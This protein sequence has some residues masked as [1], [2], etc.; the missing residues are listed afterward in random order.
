MGRSTVERVSRR[1]SFAKT[2]RVLFVK[3]IFGAASLGPISLWPASLVCVSRSLAQDLPGSSNQQ[4]PEN[5]RPIRVATFNVLLTRA[6]EGQLTKDLQGGK[7]RQA[8]AVAEIIQR[9]R[10]Q[11]LL[12]NEFD[13]DPQGKALAIFVQHYLGVG[14]HISGHPQGPAQPIRYRWTYVAPVNTGVDSGLDLDGDGRLA[15]PT[16]AFGY[17]RFPGQYA[18]AVLSQYPIQA[19]QV[20]SFQKFLWKDMPGALLPKAGGQTDGKAYYSAEV[21]ARFRLSSK[22]HWDVP[23][24][25]GSHRLHVLASHPTPPVFDGLEDRNGRRN[26]D[27]IRLW[28]DYI[29]S[30]PQAAYLY[31]DRGRRGGL[32]KTPSEAQNSLFVVMGD[33]NADPHDGDSTNKAIAQL[34]QHPLIHSKPTP[35]SQGGVEQ[36]RLQGGANR[37]HKT[38]PATDTGAF[39]GRVGH[40]RLDYVLP[41]KTL[42]VL[43]SGVFWP[44]TDDPLFKLIGSGEPVSSDH[45]LV[46]VELQLPRGH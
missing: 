13:Y 43:D 15:T 45:R 2:W 3:A 37:Q 42:R 33:Q 46:W 4:L 8:Q 22:S 18:M 34:L 12:L 44:R 23:I 27:E 7:H 10:P 1:T 29:S 35:K 6:R 30:A 25:V 26:H 36:S 21:L 28:A 40:L 11:I 20:R 14:Q 39:G 19:D 24:Q 31:D 5:H 38:D 41:S 32:A 9:V 16:D 17:G